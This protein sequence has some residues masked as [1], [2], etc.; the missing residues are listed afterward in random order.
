MGSLPHS[1]RREAGG[2]GSG[3]RL[4]AVSSQPSGELGHEAH[5]TGATL[6]ACL[7]KAP[8]PDTLTPG[9]GDLGF[10]SWIWAGDT[11][12]FL[13]YALHSCAPG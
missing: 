3:G 6:V 12:T 10:N 11:H 13:S 4:L 7:P 5:H 9:T 2:R 1:H 8:P